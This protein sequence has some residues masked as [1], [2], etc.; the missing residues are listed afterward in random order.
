MEVYE[1]IK[2]FSFKIKLGRKKKKKKIYKI[3]I[4]I[5]VFMVL[6]VSLTFIL[7]RIMHN[8]YFDEETQ[9][10]E[11]QKV[12]DSTLQYNNDPIR[13]EAK[14]EK[15]KGKID[16]IQLNGAII[17]ITNNYYFGENSGVFLEANRLD[18][19]NMLNIHLT[20]NTHILNYMDSSEIKFEDVKIGDILVYEGTIEYIEKNDRRISEGNILVLKSADLEKM[21]MEQYKGVTE[22]KNVNIVYEYNSSDLSIIKFL[23]GKLKVKSFK[24]DEFIAFFKMQISDNTI[25]EDGSTNKYADI[26]LK[27][28][29]EITTQNKSK[30]SDKENNIHEIKKITY[31]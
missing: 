25:V 23:Y 9:S 20:P 27:D 10:L 8:Y 2:I 5:V 26:V 7:V 15:I 21:K 22:L 28:N 13:Y 30:D 3:L 1:Q 11:S 31:K 16:K 24:D 17:S 6:V 18:E 4:A 19:Y 29:F 14:N 12:Q